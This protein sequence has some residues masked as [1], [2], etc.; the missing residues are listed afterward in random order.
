[1]ENILL[2]LTEHRVTSA[3]I[4]DADFLTHKDADSYAG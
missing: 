1:M 2:E 3:L 4:S